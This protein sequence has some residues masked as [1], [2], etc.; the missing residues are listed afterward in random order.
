MRQTLLLL[1]VLSVS[2]P[3]AAGPGKGEGPHP[4]LMRIH[5]LDVGQGDC[6]IVEGPED[7]NGDRKVMMVDAGETS[8]DGNEARDVV[9]PYLRRRLDDG[10]AGRPQARIDYFVATHYHKDHIGWPR[11]GKDSGFF[12]LWDTPGVKI[13]AVLDSGLGYDAAGGLDKLY[14]E[15]VDTRDVPRDTLS[16]DQL[17]EGR[18]IELG[19]DIWVEVLTVGAQMDGMD[20]RV[21]KDQWIETTSQNDFSI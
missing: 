10:P 14:A 3:A 18:Q 17:G 13:D 6:T 2:A 21:L 11:D 4:D 19:P 5:V 7:E 8:S 9:E 15:W 20:Q 12:Y 1:L 16:F